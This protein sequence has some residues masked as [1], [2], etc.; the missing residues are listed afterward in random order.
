[1]NGSIL[2]DSRNIRLDGLTARVADGQVSFDGRIGLD[3]YTPADLAL[4]A[5]GRNMRLRYPEGVRSE[6]DADLSL[7][8][9]VAAPVLA[10]TVTVQ[11]AIWTTRFDTSGNLFD[12]GGGRAAARRSWRR[13]GRPAACR[14]CASMCASSRPGTLRI[15]NN[16][17]HIVSSADLT[18]RGTY[19]RPI[20]FGRAEISRGEFIFEGR[21]YLVDARHAR[22][23]EPGADR[24]DVRHRRRDAG[25]RARPDLPR[26]PERVGNDAAAAAGVQSDPP[27]PPGRRR[28]AAARRSRDRRR[29]PICARCSVPTSPSSSWFRR[30]W[31]ACS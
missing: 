8:G 7:T 18:F 2:F 21:R 25:A 29:T 13:A 6:V 20:V 9:R 31:R 15:E 16:D 23:H 26:D 1:M 3:G 24:A 27:L 30:G 5:T 4:T 17:A 22:F 12:F 11:N 19:E 28:V 10:G 14:R